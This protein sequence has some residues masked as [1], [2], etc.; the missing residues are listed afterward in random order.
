LHQLYTEYKSQRKVTEDKIP[1]TIKNLRAEI[2]SSETPLEVCRLAAGQNQRIQSNSEEVS[3]ADAYAFIVMK[4]RERQVTHGSPFMSD[5]E[6]FECVQNLGIS[7]TSKRSDKMEKSQD[8]IVCDVHRYGV[9]IIF[10]LSENSPG[11]DVETTDVLCGKLLRQR[12]TRRAVGGAERC[13]GDSDG[14]GLPPQP[15][16]G[17]GQPQHHRHG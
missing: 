11:T 15:A 8:E 14:G 9:N 5:N 12:G 7:Y 17:R 1:D 4:C 2:L 13:R 16:E 6:V 3:T 10:S